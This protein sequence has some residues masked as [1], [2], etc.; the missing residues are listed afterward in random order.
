MKELNENLCCVDVG[1]IKLPRVVGHT[2]IVINIC[3]DIMRN[4]IVAAAVALILVVAAADFAN[5]S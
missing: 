3:I 2:L 1:W 5:V 4:S